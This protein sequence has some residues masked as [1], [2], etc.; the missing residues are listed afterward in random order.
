MLGSLV[1]WNFSANTV[2][3]QKSEEISENLGTLP[4]EY[5]P[6]DEF[7][8]TQGGT[9]GLW[10]Y[11]YSTS[12]AD[13]TLNLF[14]EATD[15]DTISSGCTSPFERWR[16]A[17]AE[18]IPQIAR[19]NPA[20]TCANIPSNALFIH[21][22]KNNQRAV[23]RFNAPTSG[24][25]Q[26]TGTFQKQAL[27]ATSDLKIIKN[28]GLPG[29][30]VLYTGVIGAVYQQTFNFTATIAAGDK[31]DFSV[32]DDGDNTWQG[33]GASIAVTIGQ[34]TTVCL[35]A[36]ANLQVNLP[37]E[38]S[39]SDVQ[40][41]NTNAQLVGDAA[42]T[43][44][45]KVG[46]AFELDGNGDYVRIEDN[47]AQ[48]PATAVTAEGWFK[49][50]NASG[51]VSLISKPVRNSALNSYTLYL[52]SGQLRGLVGNASQFTR[53]LSNFAPQTGV[54]HHLAFT[55][56]LSGGVSTLKLYANGVEVTSGVDGTA[57]L[58]LFYDANPYPL[59][60]GADFENNAPGFTLDGQADEVSVYGRALSQTEIFN[61]V[62]QG[63][64]GKCSPVK[65]A[66]SQQGLVSWFKGEGNALDTKG[67]NNGTNNGAAFSTGRVGQAFDFNGN[68]GNFVSAGTTLLNAGAADFAVEF[69]IQT[70]NNRL[71]QI[72]SK[73][74]GCTSGEPPFFSVRKLPDGRLSVEFDNA[75]GQ[76][77]LFNSTFAIT[78]GAFHHIAVQRSGNAVQLYIDGI[79]NNS[80]TGAAAINLTNNGQFSIGGSG[81]AGIDGTQTFTGKI[82]EVSVYNRAL[83]QTEIQSVFYAGGDGKCNSTACVQTPNNLVSWYAGEQNALDSRSNNHGILQN[84][85]TFQIGKV[86]QGIKFDGANDYLEIPDSPSLKPQTLT[87]ETWVKFDS[88]TS[89][90]TGGAPAGYQNI[91]FK[92]NSRAPGSGFEGGYSL[93]KNPDNKLGFGF[94]SAGGA[95]DFANST[96]AVQAG[97]WYHVVG[98][99]DGTNIRLYINGQLEGAGAATFPIDYGTTPLYLGTAQVPFSGYFNGVLDET[100]IYNRAI[101]A[102]EA[103]SIYNANSSGKCKPVAT[104]PA[105]NQIAWFSGDG[106]TRDFLGLNPNGILHGD[107]NFK[108]GRVGQSFNFDG[109][110]DYVEIA[111]DADHRPANITVEGWF[112]ANSL[113]GAPHFVSKPL[114]D[115]NS[116]SYVVW[117]QDGQMR[118]GHGNSAGGFDTLFTGFSPNPGTWYHFAY[119]IDD[120]ADTHR[121]FVN[122]VQIASAGTSLPIS[123][124]TTAPYPLLIG[125]ELDN[126]TLG[127]FLN[128]QADEVSLYS[129]ALSA[130]EIA[131]ISD[132]GTAGKLKAKP[133]AVN[134]QRNAKTKANLAP[135][136]VQLSDA[137]V[138]FAQVTT[139]GIT[140]QNNLDLGLLPKLPSGAI[141]TG[142]AYDISTTAVYQSGAADDVQVCFNV[143]ALQTF[144]FA[145]LRILHLENGVWFD[146]TA[147]GNVSPNLCTNDLTLLSPF[148][149]VQVAPTSANTSVA[150]R[151]TDVLGNGLRNVSVALTNSQGAIV[152]AKT[153]NFGRYSFNDVAAGQLYT[154]GVLS[155]RYTFGVSS[156]VVSVQEAVDNVDFTANETDFDDPLNK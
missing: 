152:Y 155:K 59:L 21:P 85:A 111:D 26:I 43:N 108:V 122:G 86:G 82:D 19:H 62:K 35:T 119:T 52:E 139:A 61:L 6:R 10:N 154:V 138:N 106:D 88:L 73:R 133:T 30:S 84:G 101:S 153:N 68:A 34:P 125:G 4:T 121:F 80:A 54:W 74:N 141:F 24:T 67:N 104:N 102:A 147:S 1:V 9:N 103:A 66:E 134:F 47:A 33:D 64:F 91:I 57:N 63:N 49:F 112:K 116:N 79:L 128:G 151:V 92:K 105:A 2:A 20:V 145:D 89:T 97:Q 94:N 76:Q 132:A 137:S 148:A 28:G 93:V 25:F 14:N 12:D 113:S 5:N 46:R 140:S 15:A 75:V 13:N 32:G 156:Q 3:A 39:P 44:T 96:T 109:T 48:R 38:N 77:V 114:R 60:I 124:D 117:Y 87:V 58:P 120:G 99:H 22:G 143:P 142:L 27:S 45:G 144:N 65:C 129:R 71:E 118:G 149:I 123:Y 36:P 100:S 126:N 50:D 95:T 107:A 135:T 31:I 56:D 127:S 16:I 98:T 53:A 81:C 18:T 11:G 70:S 78:D 17:N 146:R 29:E 131:A 23:F 40:S 41:V 115:T 110:G 72:I 130:S 83:T 55:Y 136:A 90:V 150:G 69:W 37:A 42:Y 7:A 8:L 51:I